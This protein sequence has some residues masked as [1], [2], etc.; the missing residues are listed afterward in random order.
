[1]TALTPP[2]T[3]QV[4]VQMS[5]AWFV[6]T[7]VA[8][9]P[10]GALDTTWNFDGDLSATSGTAALSFRGD[11]GTNNVSFFAS[12]HDLGLPM[13]FGD[14]SGVM[15]FEPTSPSQ[16]LTVQLNNGATTISDYTMVWDLFRPGPSW[17]SWLPLFQT[18]IA[19]TT[20]GDFFIN[21]NDGIGISGVYHGTVS[22]A[23]S[24]ISWNRIA[25]SR[26]A[27]GTLK[28]YIDGKSGRYPDRRGVAVGH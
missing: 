14:H 12:E 26:A 5:A 4:V 24:N 27:D 19:N 7:L 10:V 3:R 6:A 15:R 21:P 16:G 18:D 9:C 22:N 20:D 23:R 17:D 1:M 2:R 25:V 8:V 11:M 28:K 13:P